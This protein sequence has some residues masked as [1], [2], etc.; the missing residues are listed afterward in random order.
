[1]LSMLIIVIIC[2]LLL[3]KIYYRGVYLGKLDAQIKTIDPEVAG[4]EKTLTKNMIIKSF[5]SDKNRSLEVILKLYEFVPETIYLKGVTVDDNG[6]ISLK[7]TASAM[8]EVF[9]FVT[10]LE[11][12]GYFQNVKAQNT[13]SRKEAGKDVSDFEITC[14]SKSNKPAEPIK[15]E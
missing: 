10:S 8:S 14:L 15:K 1:M 13:S 3:V 12:S 11:N 5:L 7:G 4:L 2:I 9:S 6:D